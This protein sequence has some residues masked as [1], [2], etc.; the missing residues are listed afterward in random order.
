MIG[1][2]KMGLAKQD[3]RTRFN[4]KLFQSANREK[5]S[6][7]KKYGTKNTDYI[8]HIDQNLIFVNFKLHALFISQQNQSQTSEQSPLASS[9]D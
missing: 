8:A 2:D 1:V 3:M 6:S 5:V 7:A 9:S 4:R